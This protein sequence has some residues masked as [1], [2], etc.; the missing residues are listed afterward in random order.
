MTA[1]QHRCTRC[2]TDKLSPHNAVCLG[3]ATRRWCA[4]F[5]RSGELFKLRLVHGERLR[6]E[7]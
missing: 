4:P 7:A 3:C 2:G 5:S 6:A 1:P